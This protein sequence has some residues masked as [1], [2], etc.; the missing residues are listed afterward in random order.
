VIRVESGLA[1]GT[2]FWISDRMMTIG[3]INL[4]FGPLFFSM[5]MLRRNTTGAESI[6]EINFFCFLSDRENFHCQM[7]SREITQFF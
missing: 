1:T 2:H 6:V 4:S 5:M 3:E 7:K